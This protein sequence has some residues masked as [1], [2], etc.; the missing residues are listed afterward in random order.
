[1]SSTPFEMVDIASQ[2]RGARSTSQ[3]TGDIGL[4]QDRHN[5]VTINI[6]ST[7]RHTYH[8]YEPNAP[9]DPNHTGVPNLLPERRPKKPSLLTQLRTKFL[10]C[11]K[12]LVTISWF[13][14][15]VFGVVITFLL[16]VLAS[17]LGHM[18]Y[19]HHY[20]S[21]LNVDVQPRLHFYEPGFSTTLTSTSATATS[22][23][24][25]VPV[26]TVD[27]VWSNQ[28]T[29][30]VDGYGVPITTE[31]GSFVRVSSS[32]TQTGTPT[33]TSSPANADLRPVQSAN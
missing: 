4:R 24:K 7:H 15:A 28:P 22:T 5:D 13:H 3:Q 12:A 23:L 9:H 29:V 20:P 1:M 8:D 21:P 14:I 19:H 32:Q 31:E 2:S 26:V 30:V 10:S 11:L 6:P 27:E 16:M 25:T 17:F 33:P 18:L